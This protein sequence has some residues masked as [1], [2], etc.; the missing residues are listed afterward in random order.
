M[1][2][3]AGER[4]DLGMMREIEERVRSRLLVLERETQSLRFRTRILSFGLVGTLILVI[5]VAL[6]PDFLA[7]TGIHAGRETLSVRSLELLDGQGLR[8]GE[9][10][11][12]DEG[13]AR[14]SLLDRQGR[15]RMNLSV[16]SGGFPGLS[17]MNSSGQQRAALGLLPDETTT[18][19]FA[20]GGGIPRA[21]LGLTRGD[22]AHLVFADAEGV[23]RVAL[24][25]EGDGMG[26][27]VLPESQ[28]T[29]P[30]GR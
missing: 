14:L 27:V 22:A 4:N 8:R 1:N 24:G 11:V 13:S 16:L 19:V 18:L 6:N 20:D 12:D 28:E 25:L 23:S 26:T 10:S 2:Q 29:D 7:V 21:V 30:E 3:N 5:V 17:L 9:W 15:P